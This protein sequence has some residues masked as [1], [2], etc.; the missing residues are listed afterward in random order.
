MHGEGLVEVSQLPVRLGQVVERDGLAVR[1]LDQSK[2]LD[3]LFEERERV[4]V[5]ALLHVD[6]ALVDEAGGHV[7]LVAEFLSP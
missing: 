7:L 1:V 5:L 3:G 6:E 2:G 4:F